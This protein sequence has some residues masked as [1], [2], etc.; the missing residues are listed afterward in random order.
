MI[1]RVSALRTSKREHDS[2]FAKLPALF[3]NELRN[4]ASLASFNQ[5]ARLLERLDDFQ[6]VLRELEHVAVRRDQDVLGLDARF[7]GDI[8]MMNQ[9]PVLAVDRNEELRAS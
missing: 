6:R 3:Q 5:N 2:L 7:F 8:G 9:M 4:V 1:R